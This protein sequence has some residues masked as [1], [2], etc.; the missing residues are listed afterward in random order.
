MV[1]FHSL[2]FKTTTNFLKSKV[3][4]IYEESPCHPSRFR[5]GGR[6]GSSDKCSSVCRQRYGRLYP[7]IRP[8]VPGSSCGYCIEKVRLESEMVKSRVK[9]EGLIKLIKTM[10]QDYYHRE[11]ESEVSLRNLISAPTR[12]PRELATSI[13]AAVSNGTQGRR[14]FSCVVFDVDLKNK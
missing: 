6:R 14:H 1:Y 5:D 10:E 9:L 2:L 3:L 7:R 8:S 12:H 11:K 4:K 13:S